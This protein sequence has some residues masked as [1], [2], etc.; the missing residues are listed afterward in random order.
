M[1]SPR[2]RY[3]SD[4]TDEQWHLIEPLIPPQRSGGDKRTTDMR[5]VVNAIL[6]LNK[7]GC[8]WRDLPGDFPPHST[9]SGYFN[10]WRGDGTWKTIYDALHKK[11][12]RSQGRQETPSA[13]SIDSQSVK[14]T[15]MGG[16]RGFDG[17]KKLTGRKRFLCVDT[18]G[19]PVAV[20]VVAASVG[21]R[22]GAKQMLEAVKDELP[23]LKKLWVDGGFDGAPFSQWAH[24]VGGWVVEVVEKTGEGFTVLPRRWVVERTFAWL[25]KARR[26]CRDFER[27]CQSV[28]SFIYVTMIRLILNR[29][30]PA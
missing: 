28:E 24:E 11:L 9:V 20:H 25:Y 21:E 8:T 19:F 17:G 16:Q 7:N 10:R 12:R 26:L 3:T 5:E 4:L 15:E 30:A 14:T 6:Y 27:L 13:A 2:K 1:S 22:E 23:R 29:L 18:E